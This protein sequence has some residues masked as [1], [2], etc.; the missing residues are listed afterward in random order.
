M[1]I[2]ARWY[3]GG[4]GLD[5]F[6]S[7][8]LNDRRI[9]KIVD[10]ENSSEVV[11]GVDIAG[12]VC[13]FLWNR[14]EPGECEIETSINGKP[15]SAIRKLNEFPV[16]VRQ[17][18][19]VPIIRK[20]LAKEKGRNNLD[21]IV[22]MRKPFGIQG[23]YKPKSSG[24]PCWFTQKIGLKYAS[25]SDITDNNKY[26]DKWKLLIPRAPIAGQ[27]DFSKPVGFYYDGNTRIAKPGEC[28]T[29]SWL[30][31]GAFSTKKETLAY[32]SYLFT[33]IA[34][35]LLLQSVVSQD[36][37]RQN[38][39]F[40]PDLSPYENEYTDDLLRKKWNITEEEWLYIDSRIR[41]ISIDEE[42]TSGANDD[43]E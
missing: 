3:V 23:H 12:G 28:C 39:Q 17:S 25:K 40:V 20:I 22:S 8:M 5:D 10:F 1:I 30:V 13:F 38:F 43:E 36:V 9:R 41:H 31:A 19:A 7:E 24:I 29:E 21:I 35:F 6:R 18:K 26:L 37:T 11:P 2:P 16:L 42:V 32:K 27:T 33:K 14:D 15:Y 4:K 34:R